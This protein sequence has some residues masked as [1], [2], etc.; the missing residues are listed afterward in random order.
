MLT[1]VAR[2]IRYNLSRTLKAHRSAAPLKSII[3]H[4]KSSALQRDFDRQLL[5]TR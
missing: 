2:I 3:S 5:S 1:T 4:T